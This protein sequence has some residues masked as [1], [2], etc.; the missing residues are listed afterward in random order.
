MQ[1]G[2]KSTITFLERTFRSRS[3]H[4]VDNGERR[5]HAP[6]EEPARIRHAMTGSERAWMKRLWS[7]HARFRT[8]PTFVS[9]PMIQSFFF[10]F[11]TGGGAAGGA[12]FCRITIAG[13][14]S[15]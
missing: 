8:E 2:T 13:R 5:G 7:M 11:F 6:E 14:D 3:A 10:F 9:C 4:P 1:R 15:T 12:F